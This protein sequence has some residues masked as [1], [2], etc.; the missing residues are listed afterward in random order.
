MRFLSDNRSATFVVVS[1]VDDD[2]D[3]L[4]RLSTPSRWAQSDSQ[5]N[6]QSC[7][8]SGTHTT[9][10]EVSSARRKGRK[11]MKQEVAM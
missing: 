1:V 8:F 10:K 5:N 4:K 7:P 6:T 3:I 2:V 9:V 11:L